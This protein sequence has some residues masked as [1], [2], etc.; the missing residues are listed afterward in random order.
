MFVLLGE[1]GKPYIG[2]LTM[3][4]KFKIKTSEAGGL[5]PHTSEI[6]SLILW[7]VY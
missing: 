4:G 3:K 2:L 7:N 6:Y 5:L 1:R